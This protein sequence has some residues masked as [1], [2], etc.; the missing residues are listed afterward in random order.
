MKALVTGANG[1]T[2]SHL[3][4]LLEQRGHRTVAFVRPTSNLQRLAETQATLVKGDLCDRACLE[5]AMHAVDTVFHVAA[6][7]ELGIVDAVEMERTN[8]TG[9]QTVLAAAQA[10]GVRKFVYC[11]TV[12]VFGDTAGRAVD[13]TY[14]RQQQGFSSPY[15]RTKFLAQACVDRAAAEG[16]DAVSVLPAGIF[17]PDEP[18]FMPL[19]RWFFQGKLPVLAGGERVTGIVHVDDLCELMLLAAERAPKGERYIASAGDR[20]VRE[21]F[22]LLGRQTDRPVPPEA[23]R[24]LIRLLGNLLEPIGRRFKWQPPLSRERVHYFY[25]RCVRVDASKAQRELGWQPRSPEAI[26]QE[27]GTVVRVELARSAKT[28]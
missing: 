25:D 9:T 3:I 19:V 10:A 2:G 8:V 5:A 1:F 17:G 7:V 24:W 4:K 11:S 6:Y 12:G 23:P 26:L 20:T 13:E 18:H 21:M 14:Q 27:M 15:D 22:A 16:F 28:S